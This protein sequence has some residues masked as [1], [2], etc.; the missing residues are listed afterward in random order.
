MTIRLQEFNG[1]TH[2][3]WTKHQPYEIICDKCGKIGIGDTDFHGCIS[4]ARNKKNRWKSISARTT[5][6]DQRYLW[7]H[8]CPKCKTELRK[9]DR[10]ITNSDR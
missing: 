2:D 8:Y 5:E 1:Q 6:I 9:H 3:N 7:A 4:F 10:P